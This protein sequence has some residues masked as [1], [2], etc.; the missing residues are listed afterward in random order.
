MLES[1]G[2]LSK[3]AGVL[4]T[5]V[6]DRA[7]GAIL[8]T[9]GSLS[10]SRI[11]INATSNA[12]EPDTRPRELQG[13]DEMAAMVWKFVNTTGSLVQGLDSEVRSAP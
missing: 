13:I 10:S 12:E 4:A 5:I 1:L 2:R 11:A 9:T 8:K 3:K 7:G 6:L